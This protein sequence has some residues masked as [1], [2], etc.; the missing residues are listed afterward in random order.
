[1]DDSVCHIDDIDRSILR[2]LQLD[3]RAS[4]L[5][6]AR[7]LGVSGG[8]IHA[9]LV[10]MRDEGLVVGSRLVL[11]P[12]R[13]GYSVV[14]F[15]GLKLVKAHDCG[16]LMNKLAT[17]PEVLNVHY[18][19]GAYS[20]FIKIMARTMKDLHALLFDRLQGFDEIQSTETFIVLD[21]SLDRDIAP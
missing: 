6:I 4:Y 13:L 21:T 16:G 1:M 7:E 12:A 15:I 14:A 2:K 19:T 11:D 17:I 10:R 18:T 9:R 3:A 8:T 5:E 20:L